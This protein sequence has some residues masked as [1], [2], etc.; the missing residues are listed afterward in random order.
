M[1]DRIEKEKEE[2]LQLH[3]Q[4]KVKEHTREKAREVA[5]AQSSKESQR[6]RS[7]A[8]T[9]NSSAPQDRPPVAGADATSAEAA[10]TALRIAAT[11]RPSF[12]LTELLNSNKS[13]YSKLGEIDIENKRKFQ[14][15]YTATKES[16]QQIKED[17]Q[18]LG[19][20]RD[21]TE[22]NEIWDSK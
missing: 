12:D 16:L 11:K 18:H 1:F 15:Q 20:K 5:E 7:P 13:Y 6:H 10:A 14:K 21:S 3:G 17:V 2:Q 19:G 9:L 8:K 22:L 4:S